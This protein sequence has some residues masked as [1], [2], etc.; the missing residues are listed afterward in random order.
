MRF[1]VRALVFGV[2]VAASLPIVIGAQSASESARSEAR[3]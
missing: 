1:A 2:A 3:L